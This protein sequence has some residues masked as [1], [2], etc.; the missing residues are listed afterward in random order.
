MSKTYKAVF[1]C[2][3]HKER[4]VWYVSS[5]LEAKRIARQ[6]IT[7][8]GGKLLKKYKGVSYSVTISE[9]FKDTHEVYYDL[10]SS[11]GRD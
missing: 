1:E 10:V 6:H 5:R 7:R 9:V 2:P 3:E 8:V 11:W 4:E